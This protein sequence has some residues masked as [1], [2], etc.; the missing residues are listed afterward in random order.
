MESQI[1]DDNYCLSPGAMVKFTVIGSILVIR[2]WVTYLNVECL[3][4]VD[5]I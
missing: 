4:R 2:A 1:K 3:R 5:L